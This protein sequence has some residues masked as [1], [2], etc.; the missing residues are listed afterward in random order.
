[1]S[2]VSR[3]IVGRRSA[4]CNLIYMAVLAALVVPGLASAATTNADK[5]D[6]YPNLPVAPYPHQVAPVFVDTF[7]IPGHVLYRFDTQIVNKGGTLDLYRAPNGDAMQAIWPGGVPT[8]LY[9]DPS[10]GAKYVDPS[11]APTDPNATYEDLSVMNGASF[12]YSAAPGHNHWHFQSAARYV[13]NL[14]NG[15]VRDSAKVGFCMSD[16]NPN[17]Y[18]Y[19]PTFT[20]SGSQEFC[21]PGMPSAT[22]VRMGLSPNN[23]DLYNSQ[24]AD[25]WID[26]T[27][28]APGNY[29]VTATVNPKGYIDESSTA[30]NSITVTR[31]IPGTTAAD[32][33]ATTAP[34]T[35]KDV[36]LSGTVVG[37]T[38]PARASG[39]NT[40]PGC[41]PTSGTYACYIPTT[42]G[43]TVPNQLQFAIATAPA[44]GT[45]TIT[46]PTPANL[47]AVAHYTPAAGYNGTDSFTYTT[48]DARGLVSLPATVTMTVGTP[49]PPPPPPPSGGG[50]G[51]GGAG[52]SAGTPNL[53]VTVTAS[54]ASFGLQG[55]SEIAFL[56][57]NA[58]AQSSL[59]T[60]LA[61]QLPPS[62]T[63][64]G[65]PGYDRGSGCTGTVQIDC[66]LDFLPAGGTTKIFFSVLGAASG[67][68]TVVGTVTSSNTDSDPTDNTA[69]VAVQVNAPFVP[70]AQTPTTTP[71]SG[72]VMHTVRV[73][74]RHNTIRKIAKW[75]L[76]NATKWRTIY[77]AN[78][79]WFVVRH[80]S[81]A[82]APDYRLRVGVVIRY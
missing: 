15:D 69:S 6:L 67:P 16:S 42:Q 81:L 61:I 2:S 44:H 55:Y 23:L 28:L 9:T 54:P 20:G 60:H 37:P 17:Y 18:P 50:G 72:K 41:P 19:G 29:P 78:R 38:I 11:S 62:L 30:N 33:S 58:G 48:T 70:P 26:V 64:V 56:V 24:V 3:L 5:P 35:A 39:S 12:I 25:Q 79:H 14:P 43:G 65:P 40:D 21:A 22:F 66:N 63:L 4:R 52:G 7:A 59:Q 36:N 74:A 76:G 75:K 27:G 49:P 45:V 57:K 73:D 47:T 53:G 34:D 51:G 1:M 8:Q 77:I 10:T 13:L 82:K 80:I 68:A 46:A 71:S 31:M 32:A